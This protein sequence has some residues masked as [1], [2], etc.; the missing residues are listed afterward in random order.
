MS[1]L[2]KEEK[3]ADCRKI[4]LL[5]GDITHEDADA[6]VNA[7]N[8]HLMHGGGVAAAIVHAGGGIIQKLSNE[9]VAKHGP[10]AVGSAIATG[11]GNLPCKA[12]IH[13]VGPRWGEGD[14]DEKLRGAI[15]AS[16]D[17]ASQ[18]GF[19]TIAFPAISSGIFGFP[20]DRC[21]AIFWH[22]VRQWLDEHGATSLQQV[23]FV[24]YDNETLSHFQNQSIRPS[25]PAN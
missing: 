12:V 3:R 14:E 24:I 25:K 13:A 2:I 15:R 23:R 4:V 20:K 16:L 9:H 8:S 5:Q 21:A 22:T 17:L 1:Q 11:P 6:I 18:R 19:K 10:V 7:A